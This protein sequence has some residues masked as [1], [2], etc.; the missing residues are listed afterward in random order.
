MKL[1]RECRKIS[2]RWEKGRRGLDYR[3][4]NKIMGSLEGVYF[5]GGLTIGTETMDRVCLRR[6]KPFTK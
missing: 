5:R 4:V 1:R 6:G 2:Q 3:R